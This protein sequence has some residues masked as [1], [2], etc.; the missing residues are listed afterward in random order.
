MKVFLDTNILLDILVERDNKEFTENAMTIVELGSNG[1]I[2][3]Y[4]SV[5]SVT[6]IA[7]VLKNMPVAKKKVI[8]KELTST[9]KVLPSLPVHVNEML[10]SPMKDIEDAMQVLSARE[11]QCDLIV[12]R[13]L[14]D[15]CDADMPVIDPE[16]FLGRILV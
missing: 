15:F 2:D 10:E 7:Y 1:D 12:T 16:D 3:L 14:K 8:I 5:L 6:T 4:M 13:N 9:V 11:G